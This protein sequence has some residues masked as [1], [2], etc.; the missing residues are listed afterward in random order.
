[1]QDVNHFSENG[2]VI[3]KDHERNLFVKSPV[4]KPN[5]QKTLL[6]TSAAPL[7]SASLERGSSSSSAHEEGELSLILKDK[8]SWSSI[9]AANSP[10]KVSPKFFPP[11]VKDG[12]I[13][14]R[15][16]LEVLRKGK[17]MWCNSLVGYF[18]HSR[19]PFKVVEPIV[20]KL[21]GSMGLSKVLLHEKGYYIFKFNSADNVLALG[22]WY[23]SNKQI[24]LKHWKEGIDITKE[25]CPK[26]P[27]WVKLCNVPLSYW[28]FKGLSYI[29]SGV[30]KPLFFDKV[31]E[32]I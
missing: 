16:P 30:S 20:Q 4:K 13:S 14:I 17:D 8:P 27:I 24:M 26:A 12:V 32:K 18:L 2:I 28:N 22:P 25:S 6:V 7:P 29:S 9:V 19:L 21:W 11:I 3:K 23:I 5:S 15:P 31:I 1:M 10:R